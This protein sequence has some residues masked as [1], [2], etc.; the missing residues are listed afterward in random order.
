MGEEKTD[1]GAGEVMFPL[2]LYF[3]ERVRSRKQFFLIILI[4]NLMESESEV[5]IG[6]GR[7]YFCFEMD[8]KSDDSVFV[9]SFTSAKAP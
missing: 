1:S 5:L 7:A 8:D 9:A 6:R 4:A 2:D 3:I